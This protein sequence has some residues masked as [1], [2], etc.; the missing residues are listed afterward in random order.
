MGYQAA[1]SQA[2]LIGEQ[3]RIEAQMT[4]VQDN[5]ARAAFR[6][7][8]AQQRAELAAR[9]VQMDSPTAIMLGQVAAKEM[10]FESQ[11]I[12]ATGQARQTELS[13]SQAAARA[14]ATSSLLKG[15]FSAADKVL[16]A[17]PDLWPGMNTR[18]VR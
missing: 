12:R 18:V 2:A 4:T 14:E 15:T 3:K 17:A 7:Q 9:G 6:S 10:S 1:S 16:T 13:Y 11:S 5:R 8:I